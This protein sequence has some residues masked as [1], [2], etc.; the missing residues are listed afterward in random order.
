LAITIPAGIFLALFT[1]GA[2]HK[3]IIVRTFT[4]SCISMTKV[5][6]HIQKE[7][8]ASLMKRSA[9]IQVCFIGG[10]KVLYYIFS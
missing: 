7:C 2:P 5:M 3:K 6:H 10:T 4:A 1:E 8:G 9:D